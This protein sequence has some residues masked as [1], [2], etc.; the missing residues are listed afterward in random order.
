[1]NFTAGLPIVR[2][3]PDH[4]ASYDIAGRDEADPQSMM[5]AIYTAID[6]LRRREAYDKLKASVSFKSTQDILE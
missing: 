6:I 2:T 5:S 1:M 3:A 4:G